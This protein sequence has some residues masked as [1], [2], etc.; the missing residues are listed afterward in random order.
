MTASDDA[1]ELSVMF[2]DSR[3]LEYVICRGPRYYLLDHR[4]EDMILYRRVIR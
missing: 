1:L 4:D 3:I 2:G